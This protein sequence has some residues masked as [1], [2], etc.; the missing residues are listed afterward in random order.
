MKRGIEFLEEAVLVALYG[1]W[2]ITF[3]DNLK[4]TFIEEKRV[5]LILE[6]ITL[7]LLLMSLAM[8]FITKER[9]SSNLWWFHIISLFVIQIIEWMLIPERLPLKAFNFLAVGVMFWILI[10]W[11]SDIRTRLNL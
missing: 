2:L 8:Y 10:E 6:S 11:V 7:M 3:I 9:R 5:L 1:N 4:F